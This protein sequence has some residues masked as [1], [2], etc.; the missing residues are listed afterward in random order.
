MDSELFARVERA[1]DI[2]PGSLVSD[3]LLMITQMPVDEIEDWIDG[4][5]QMSDDKGWED[6]VR[7]AVV[8]GRKKLAAHL[9]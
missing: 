5:W 2:A 9:Q 7:R 6:R 3:T 1:A 4:G 8:A